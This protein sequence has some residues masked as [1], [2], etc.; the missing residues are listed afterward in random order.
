MNSFELENNR[1]IK[2]LLQ[3]LETDEDVLAKEIGVAKEELLKWKRG[4]EIPPSWKKKIQRL[5]HIAEQGKNFMS[6]IEKMREGIEN[7]DSFEEDESEVFTEDEAHLAQAISRDLQGEIGEF[8][9]WNAHNHFTVSAL[10]SCFDTHIFSAYFEKHDDGRYQIFPH[11]LETF[12]DISNT[13]DAWVCKQKQIASLGE[14]PCEV[15]HLLITT[16]VNL[17]CR[18]LIAEGF[19]SDY[20]DDGDGCADSFR[21]SA[22]N[23]IEELFELEKI[24]FNDIDVNYYEMLVSYEELQYSEFGGDPGDGQNLNQLFPY[25]VDVQP[26]ID[27]HLSL[28]AREILK[29]NRLTLDSSQY[30]ISMVHKLMEHPNNDNE[31][32]IALS[33]ATRELLRIKDQLERGDAGKQT[34]VNEKV[35]KAGTSLLAEHGYIF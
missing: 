1:L 16:I 10:I 26:N 33:N 28:E 24:L 25:S 2:T 17:T 6:L 5:T 3:L 8:G 9:I 19:D 11:F 34:K 18:E 20:S 29:V 21:T 30:L 35:L 27:K 23:S 31:I 22:R 32:L 14:L 7:G 4:Q 12:I 13:Y 15:A